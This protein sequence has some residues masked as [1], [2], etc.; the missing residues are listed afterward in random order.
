MLLK[1]ALS[2]INECRNLL[3]LL[4]EQRHEV[5]MPVAIEI[6]REDI[7]P[8]GPFNHAMIV[9]FLAGCLLQPSNLALV[10]VTVHSNHKVRVT[11]AVKIRR[12][13]VRDSRDMVEDGDR[14]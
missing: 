9:V 4:G 14:R 12:F 8:S 7:D 11:V 1:P 10:N 5:S 3:V 2:V 13:D 6:D